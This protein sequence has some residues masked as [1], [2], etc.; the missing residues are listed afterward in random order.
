M[1]GD[2]TFTLGLVIGIVA[3]GDAW[4]AGGGLPECWEPVSKGLLESLPFFREK[5]AKATIPAT[6]T[7]AMMINGKLFFMITTSEQTHAAFHG[8]RRLRQE[9][10]RATAQAIQCWER[11][12]VQTSPRAPSLF[13]AVPSKLF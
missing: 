7:T 1:T 6:S 8:R 11:Q 10:T 12:W 9:L 4:P 2:D 3:A 13:R 5:T